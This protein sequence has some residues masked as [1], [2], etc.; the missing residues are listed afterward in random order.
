[1]HIQWEFA[2]LKL[3]RNLLAT[4]RDRGMISMNPP[5]IWM[6][7]IPYIASPNVTTDL[8][9]PQKASVTI[10]KYLRLNMST[11]V[12]DKW[13]YSKWPPVANHILRVQLSRDHWRQ[14][15]P[16]SDSITLRINSYS[17]DQ[18]HLYN[19]NQIGLNATLGQLSLP[20]LRGK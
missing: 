5:P 20:S 11:T 9:W 19:V 17:I 16:Q 6:Q 18:Y 12:Q 1:M 4:M 3:I 8:T 10:T 2:S 13:V 7:V 14:M 15:N